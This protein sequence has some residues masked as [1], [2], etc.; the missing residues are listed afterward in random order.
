MRPMEGDIPPRYSFI[1]IYIYIVQHP[2]VSGPEMAH[3][4]GIGCGA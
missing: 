2:A 1:Y 4:P 3:L